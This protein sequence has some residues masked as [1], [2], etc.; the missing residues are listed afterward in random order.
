MGILC[1]RWGGGEKGSPDVATCGCDPLKLCRLEP[2]ALLTSFT[3]QPSS[4]GTI[5]QPLSLLAARPADSLAVV[6][7]SSCFMLEVRLKR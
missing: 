6:M 3:H 7:P 1:S 5:T 2:A 4:G